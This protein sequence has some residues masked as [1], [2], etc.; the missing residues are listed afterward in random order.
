MKCRILHESSGRMR[1]HIEQ[2]RMTLQQADLIEY[3]IRSL[4]CVENVRV[5][6]RTGNA[7]IAYRRGNRHAVVQALSELNYEDEKFHALVPEHSGREMRNKYEEKLLL[8][9]LSKGF[10]TLFFPNVLNTAITVVSSIPYFVKGVRSL[11]H[12]RIEVSVLDAAAIGASLL[13]GDPSTA[14][15]VIFLQNIGDTLEEWTREKSVDDLAE[16]MSLHVDR[17]WIKCPDGEEVLM[18][19]GDVQAGD[20]VVVRTSNVIP[21]D[22]IVVSGEASVNQASMTGEAAPVFKSEGATVFAGTVVSEGE[23]IYRVTKRAGKGKYDQ[24]VKMIE[25]SEKLKSNTVTA[26]Y[27]LADQLVTGAFIGMGLTY[28]LTRN[29]TRAMSFLMVDFSCALKLSMPLAVMSAMRDAGKYEISVKGGK[30]LEAVSEAE[31]IVFDKTGTL[32]Y[33]TPK[34]ADIVTFDGWSETEALR[35]AACMEEHFPHSIANAVVREAADRKISHEEYHTK[36]EYIVAHGIATTI[37]GKRAVIGSHHFVMEDEKIRVSDSEREKYHAIPANYSPLYLAVDGRLAAVLCIL[38]PI[39]EEAAGVI[40]QLHRMGLKKICMMTGDNRSTAREVAK[41]LCLDEF[42][43]EV[44]PEDKAE[45]VRSE[46]ACG[47]KVIMVGDGIND[48]PA[49]SE[50]DVGLAVSNGAPIAQEVADIVISNG[51]LQEIV[52]MRQIAEALM[53]RIHGNYR[54][55]MGFNSVL[56]ALG[57]M[58]ILMPS[59]AS[60]LHNLSTIGIGLHSMTPLIREEE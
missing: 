31:T 7:I 4:D 5:Y 42:H 27:H 3:A 22:G 32:T 26:A 45:F 33:A 17:V 29:I 53:R 49:L 38:D 8:S 20:L 37:D 23:L 19:T 51:S 21:L 12:G 11:L 9:V 54:N 47:R 13:R 46:H 56:I 34:V 28:L 6:E 1:V 48:T 2:F 57:A 59:T 25:E 41:R 60:L 14:G 39:R 16:M 30:F 52:R 36:V 44:L 24:I 55:I 35:L 58:G 18:D 50:A 15:S 10:R 40:E 43:A